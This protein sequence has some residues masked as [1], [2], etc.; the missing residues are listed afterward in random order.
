MSPT[1][2]HLLVSTA[3]LVGLLGPARAEDAPAAPTPEPE[4]DEGLP[5]A[6]PSVA[7]MPTAAAPVRASA[8]F[9]SALGRL[10]ERNSSPG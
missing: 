1:G 8:G 6:A 9:M 7:P 3:L 4:A 10:R 5:D 2:S